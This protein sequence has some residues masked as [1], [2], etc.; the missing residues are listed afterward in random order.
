MPLLTDKL[1]R[2]ED[3]EYRKITLVC[4]TAHCRELFPIYS[5][6]PF[7][8]WIDYVVSGYETIKDKTLESYVQE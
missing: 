4:T 8:L 6:L 7:S 1:N 2:V 5:R 3:S